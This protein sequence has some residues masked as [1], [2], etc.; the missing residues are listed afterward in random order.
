V[1]RHWL[2][3]SSSCCLLFDSVG[4]QLQLAVHGWIRSAGP[5]PAMSLVCLLV[6]LHV[7]EPRQLGMMLVR[8]TLPNRL[9]SEH[10]VF[11]KSWEGCHPLIV[12]LQDKLAAQS[13]AAQWMQLLQIGVCVAGMGM[14]AVWS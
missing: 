8:H 14:R 2:G 12:V 3:G 1:A 11:S 5:K 13:F 10:H 7:G 9:C 6:C 4:K